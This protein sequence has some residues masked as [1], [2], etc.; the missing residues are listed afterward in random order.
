MYPPP[1]DIKKD[2]KIDPTGKNE[3]RYW[4]GQKWTDHVANNEQRS[5]DPIKTPPPPLDDID[6]DDDIYDD[7]IYEDNVNDNIYNN[8]IDEDNVD[9]DIYEDDIE[10][11]IYEDDIVEDNEEQ[12]IPVSK[13]RRTFINRSNSIS[14]EDEDDTRIRR[15]SLPSQNKD[16]SGRWKINT[17]ST[18]NNNYNNHSLCD[19][20]IEGPQPQRRISVFFRLILAIPHFIALSFLGIGAAIFLIIAWFSA[21]FTGRVPDGIASYLENFLHWNLRVQGYLF[22]LTDVYPPF[23]LGPANYPI[24]LRLE[25]SESLSRLNVLFRYFFMMPLGF[26]VEFFLYGAFTLFGFIAWVATLVRGELP[27]FFANPLSVLLRYVSQVYAFNYLL[28]DDFPLPSNLSNELVE[29]YQDQHAVRKGLGWLAASGLMTGI[30]S[31]VILTT[32]VS[33]AVNS[34]FNTGAYGSAISSTG[35]LSNSSNTTT[36]TPGSFCTNYSIVNKNLTN[37]GTLLTNGTSNLSQ[38][39]SDMKTIKLDIE[40]LDQSSP[41]S[42]K[43]DIN[44]MY[45]SVI[46]LANNVPLSQSQVENFLNKANNISI[47]NNNNLSASNAI[48]NYLSSNCS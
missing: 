28:V 19:V 24:S 4:N 33:G 26:I 43:N 25:R 48:M 5:I 35:S 3:Y 2:W 22:L 21:L 39:D 29:N 27:E 6:E 20:A 13:T 7:D 9:D 16:N 17:N 42:I 31:F 36:N 23:T 15:E 30:L 40:R 10:D 47:A 1:K 41:P 46:D 14:N 45:Q 37:L 12:H 32:E 8:D 18:N 34:S 11:D 38:L 44:I